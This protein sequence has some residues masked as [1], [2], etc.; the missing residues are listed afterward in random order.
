MRHYSFLLILL[1]FSLPDIPVAQ[2]PYR[3]A[4][5]IVAFGKAD[6]DLALVSGMVV[7]T[8]SSSIRLW[9]DLENCFEG[10]RILNRGFGGSHFSDLLFYADVLILKYRPVKVFIYEGD[11][12]IAEGKPPDKIMK[13]S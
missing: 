4:Q 8:G 2:S 13:R 9:E 7:F 12:D 6:K 3:F 5:E 1:L 11:N 10:Y